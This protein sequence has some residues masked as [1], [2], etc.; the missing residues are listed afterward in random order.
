[1]HLKSTDDPATS[2]TEHQ[3]FPPFSPHPNTLI[4]LEEKNH[5][6]QRQP[7]LLKS[8]S[9]KHDDELLMECIN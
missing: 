5:W 2:P 1:M 9:E 6:S 3:L 4:W 8:L 7:V